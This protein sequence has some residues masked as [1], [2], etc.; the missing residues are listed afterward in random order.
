MVLLGPAIEDK[1]LEH[2]FVHVEQFE[3]APF[4]SMFLMWIDKAKN[5]NRYSTYED[6]AYRRAG[7]V[8]KGEEKRK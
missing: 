6:E 7:N 1:D 5:G 4:I 2:E 3:R 8:W